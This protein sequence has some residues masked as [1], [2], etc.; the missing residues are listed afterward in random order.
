MLDPISD[1]VLGSRAMFIDQLLSSDEPVGQHYFHN[2]TLT[3]TAKIRDPILM[4]NL[5]PEDPNSAAKIRVP[6]PPKLSPKSES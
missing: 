3:E 5:S 2:K 4:Q 6:M 1:E